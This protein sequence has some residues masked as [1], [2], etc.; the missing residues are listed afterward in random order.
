MAQL[1][2]ILFSLLLVSSRRM[3]VSA[4]E[5]VSELT[6]MRRQTGLLRPH[7]MSMLGCVLLATTVFGG[8]AEEVRRF[9]NTRDGK[10]DHWEY[11]RDGV[12]LRVAVDRNQGGCADEATF[13]RG[14][15]VNLLRAASSQR[16]L[17]ESFNITV[18]QGGT[19]FLNKEPTSL[20]A[21]GRQVKDGLGK[22]SENVDQTSDNTSPVLE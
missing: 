3:V 16:D 22:D 17:R 20:G 11:Y 7:R 2:G 21:L 4:V 18:M 1:M 9:D 8:T 19:L 6:F 13:N 12:L 14:L 5:R 10:I 15:Q